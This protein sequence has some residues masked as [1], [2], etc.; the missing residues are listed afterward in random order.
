MHSSCVF[1]KTLCTY[2]SEEHRSRL[3]SSTLASSTDTTPPCERIQ[4]SKDLYLYTSQ[5]THD[6]F[7]VVNMNTLCWSPILLG[8]HIVVTSDHID[9][10]LI[11]EHANLMPYD[12]ASFCGQVDNILVFSAFQN[13]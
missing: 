1:K 11:V 7:K 6:L 13:V 12:N 3:V 4:C 2:L 9:Y 8:I 5:K 10:I